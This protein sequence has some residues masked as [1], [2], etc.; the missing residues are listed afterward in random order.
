[1]PRIPRFRAAVRALMLVAM[2]WVIPAV[3][4]ADALAARLQALAE[5]HGFRL[6][7]I[8][9]VGSEPAVSAAGDLTAQLRALLAGYNHVVEGVPPAVQRVIILGA[10]QPAPRALVAQTTRRHGHHV[11]DAKLQGVIGHRVSTALIVDT[12]ASSLVLPDSMMAP[13]GFNSDDLK[14]QRGQ[15][16][17]GIVTG[18]AASLASVT[19]GGATAEDVAVLFVADDLLGDV[20][21]LGMSFLG[22]FSITIDEA[23]NRLVLTPR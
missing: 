20:S 15:S 18:H 6:E 1:M 10:K 21:L 5:S 16:V 13:L 4:T 14:E 23:G 17:N 3:G 9:K 2:G 19:V 22:R 12:G 7:G 11:V 8:E